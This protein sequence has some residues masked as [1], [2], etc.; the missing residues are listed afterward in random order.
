MTDLFLFLQVP[1]QS[2]LGEQI[3]SLIMKM[4]QDKGVQFRC[5]VGVA[6]IVCD[7]S[8]KTVKKLRLTDDSQVE[9]DVVVLGIGKPEIYYIFT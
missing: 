5:G 4:H 8:R 1:F 2:S 7:E 3:G 9:A 6:G